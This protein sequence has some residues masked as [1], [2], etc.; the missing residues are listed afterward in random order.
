LVATRWDYDAILAGWKPR[1][2]R[3]IQE[4]AEI[5]RA[6][7]NCIISGHG[8]IAPDLEACIEAAKELCRS[9]PPGGWCRWSDWERYRETTW[10]DAVD[11]ILRLAGLASG[12][13]ENLALLVL[14]LGRADL[15]QQLIDVEEFLRPEEKGVSRAHLN[16]EMGDCEAQLRVL[17][18]IVGDESR[19][20]AAH[21]HAWTCLSA[22]ERS[23]RVPSTT[24]SLDS[25][26]GDAANG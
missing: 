17:Q 10:H 4:W 7:A 26:R 11:D 6:I 22:I 16:A 14:N 18:N 5:L 24:R 9:E 15:G 3:R 1:P 21:D 23:R 12:D 19:S 2:S 8:L 13:V 20:S 25:G